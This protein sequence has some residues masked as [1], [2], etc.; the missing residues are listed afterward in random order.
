MTIDNYSRLP[1]LPLSPAPLLPTPQ[2]I[3]QTLNGGLKPNNEPLVEYVRNINP[4]SPFLTHLQ[5]LLPPCPTDDS[6]KSPPERTGFFG[7]EK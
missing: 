4:D 6:R 3:R 5:S 1:L 7:Q 2:V